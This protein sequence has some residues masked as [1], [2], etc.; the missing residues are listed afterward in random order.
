MNVAETRPLGIGELLRAALAVYRAHL[1]T[2]VKV[3]APLVIPV[4]AVVVAVLFLTGIPRSRFAGFDPAPALDIL[5][6]SAA[7]GPLTLLASLLAAGA[8][9]Q[10]VGVA[11]L[12]GEPDWRESLRFAAR[13]L[14]ALFSLILLLALG[15]TAGLVLLVLPALWVAVT[16]SLALPALVFEGTRG[17]GALK[18]SASLVRGRWWQT[19]IALALG[20]VLIALVQQAVLLGFFVLSLRPGGATAPGFGQQVLTGSVSAILGVPLFATLIGLLYFDARARK[21]GLDL[22]SLA[23]VVGTDA[24]GALPPLPAIP[25]PRDLAR[26]AKRALKK[27]A[28]KER[29]AAIDPDVPI[30]I[31]FTDIEGSTSLTEQLGD[32]RARELGRVHDSIVRAALAQHGGVEVKH[33][34]DGVMACFRS[35][36]RAVECA[37]GIQR[38]IASR[39]ESAAVTPIQVRIGI[40]AGEAVVE[41]GD[42]F[43]IAVQVASR[44]TSVARPGQILATE[45][46]RQLALGK[47]LGFGDQGV[48]ELRGFAEPFRLYHV[49]WKTEG[50]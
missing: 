8:C 39:N 34:G 31:L 20:L 22:E 40:N 23:R 16:W 44:V 2:F 27:L 29:A 15:V 9:L 5:V 43:G 38:S 28:R 36:S 26:S 46:V 11:Y 25:R 6:F 35:P 14:G 47:D 42:L 7:S 45:V 13:R 4:E 33:T 50:S 49:D 32:T 17:R 24:P 48:T 30:A 18:R 10:A 37:I 3:L 19:A 12:G 41:D 21:E 1:G